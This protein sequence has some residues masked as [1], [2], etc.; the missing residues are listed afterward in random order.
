MPANLLSLGGDGGGTGG[1]AAA[2]GTV[3]LS[4][5]IEPALRQILVEVAAKLLAGWSPDFQA[6]VSLLGTMAIM[7]LITY[8]AAKAAHHLRPGSTNG[9]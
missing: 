1:T 4:P 3:T 7:L 9:Q 8:G 6:N 2:L 5:L